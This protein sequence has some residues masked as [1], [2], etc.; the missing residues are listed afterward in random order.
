MSK[1]WD[2]RIKSKGLVI[3][4]YKIPVAVV[5]FGT[6]DLPERLSNHDIAIAGY[7]ETE[8]NG[9]EKIIANTVSNPNIRHV[10]VCGEEV[11]GHVPGQSFLALHKY[12]IDD[13]G[14]II[15]AKGHTPRIFSF[16]KPYEVVKR[17]QKQVEVI[18]MLGE[19]D[20]EK[21]KQE[22]ESCL[23]KNKGHYGEPYI[24]EWKERKSE[25]VYSDV[26]I[27]IA[28]RVSM[29]EEGWIGLEEV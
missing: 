28:P 1:P 6:L 15:N 19:T 11:R 10:I 14:F 16:E 7:C 17:F 2:V 21:I 26:G 18:D 4:N 13:E 24:V 29:N 3:G 9:L 8:N 22:I 5:T 12:G 23:E 20:I 25:F 27:A